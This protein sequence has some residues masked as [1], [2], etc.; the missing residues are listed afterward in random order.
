MSQ[1]ED[2]AKDSAFFH[3]GP[4]NNRNN[5]QSPAIQKYN[6]RIAESIAEEA[7][8]DRDYANNKSR[9]SNRNKQTKKESTLYKNQ[10]DELDKLMDSRAKS[11]GGWGEMSSVNS[12]I[13]KEIDELLKKKEN[14]I[15]SNNNGRPS[16]ISNAGK[17]SLSKQGYAYD[18]VTLSNFRL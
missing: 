17:Q 15:E 13:T 1:V 10:H 4:N 16:S 5:G 3:K 11:R 9:Q 18:G 14:G 2:F 8:E 6:A 7:D 12:D